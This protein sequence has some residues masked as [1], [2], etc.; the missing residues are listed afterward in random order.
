LVQRLLGHRDLASSA[1]YARADDRRL[2]EAMSAD[3]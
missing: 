3:R 1:V 2:R